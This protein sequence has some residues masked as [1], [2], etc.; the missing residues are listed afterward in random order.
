MTPC[1]LLIAGNGYLGQEIADQALAL[2]S[3]VTTLN[4]SGE[5][6]DL[7]CDLTDGS[8]VAALA[9]S[10]SPTHIVAC[11]SSGRGDTE[12]YREIFLD[13]TSHLLASFPTAKL[14]FISSSSVYRQEDGAIVSEESTT[15]GATAKS[16]VLRTAEELVLADEGTCLRLAGIYGPHR[17]II[18]KKFLSGEAILEETEDGLGV[19]ILNQIHVSDAASAV[20]HLISQRKN[21]LYNVCDNEPTSQL[22]TYQQLAEKLARPLPPTGLPQATKRGWTNKAV[23]NLK[24]R[25][26]GWEPR[27][28]HFLSAVDDLLPTMGGE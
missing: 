18:L 12:A 11:A 8:A 13:G 4:R 15:A 19:R 6:A 22:T 10:I 7:A 20:L 17:S 16:T 25:A 23:S 21:G 1:S 5:G 27:Y 14:T 24:L 26:T 9:E 28:P 2:G 3:Q